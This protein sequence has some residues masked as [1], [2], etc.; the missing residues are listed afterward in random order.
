MSR[1]Q[2]FKTLSVDAFK[3]EMGDA[4]IYTTTA[5]RDTLDEAPEAYKNKDDIVRLIE[6]TAR[7]LF[8]LVPRM[9]IKSAEGKPVWNK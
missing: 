8:F 4:G 9:N 3:A 5:N 1:A 6:P 2:A 7:I